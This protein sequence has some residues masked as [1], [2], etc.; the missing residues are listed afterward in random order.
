M[1]C[2]ICN[3]AEITEHISACPQCKSDL[4]A[5][6]LSLKMGRKSRFITI[7]SIVASALAIIFLAFLVMGFINKGDL[8]KKNNSGMTEEEILAIKGDLE[9]VRAVNNDLQITN[10]ELLLKISTL[11]KASVKKEQT[12]VVKEG[13]SLFVIARKILGNGYKYFDIARDNN[14]TDPDKLKTG[15][16]LIIYY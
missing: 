5:I 11:E 15:Q 12:Y 8:T 7:F 6:H 16:T 9:N 2:P 10:S 4:E 14:I 1:N 3:F 13:E